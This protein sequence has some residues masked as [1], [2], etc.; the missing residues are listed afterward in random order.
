M[1]QNHSIEELMNILLKIHNKLGSEVANDGDLYISLFDDLLKRN[2]AA[3]N[4]LFINAWDT[5]IFRRIQGFIHLIP[6]HSPIAEHRADFIHLLQRWKSQTKFI[7]LRVIFGQMRIGPNF[8]SETAH[9]PPRLSGI[10]GQS[11]TSID[12]K[13]FGHGHGWPIHIFYHNGNWIAANNRGYAAH[14]H[15]GIRPKRLIPR[16]A[17]VAET[18]RLAEAENLPPTPGLTYIGGYV[19]PRHVAPRTLPSEQIPITDGPNSWSIRKT[20]KVPEFWR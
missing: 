12:K 4:S 18:N 15:I 11:I 14:C 9:Q 17:D 1:V 20:I 16:H 13:H 5:S 8:A 19:G 7:P 2:E 3:G 6:N 10:A